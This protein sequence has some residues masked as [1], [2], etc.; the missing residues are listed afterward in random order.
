M[1]KEK[2]TDMAASVRQRLLNLAQETKEDFQLVLTR[3]AIERMLFRLSR[4]D[5]RQRFVLKGAVLFQTWSKRMHR[6]TLDLDLHGVGESEL[7]AVRSVFASVCRQP[8]EN[9]GISFDPESVEVEEIREDQEYKG[10]RIRVSAAIGVAKIPVQIDVGFGDAITPKP[11]S[12]DFPSLLGLPAPHLKAYP[13]ETVVAEKYQAMVKLGIANSRMKDFFD[14]WV[15][16]SES[17]F[18]GAILCRAIGATFKR[19]QTALPTDTPLALTAEFADDAT[20]QLQWG[21]F[22]R[23]GR[24][25]V[26]PVALAEVVERLSEFLMPPTIALREKEHF[27]RSWQAGGP[28]K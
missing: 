14:L 7:G 15:L 28:W 6:A 22:I 13:K 17:A 3:Y 12:I 26:Q 11:V 2:P 5:Y 24:L 18:D 16:A 8:V 1:T 4:S 27:T 10:V 21:G 25:T 23:K 20:K 19:R 9:D